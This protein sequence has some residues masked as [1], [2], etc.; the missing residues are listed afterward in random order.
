VERVP[1][2]AERMMLEL[3]QELS[4]EILKPYKAQKEETIIL[5]VGL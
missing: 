1:L 2:V 5:I 4:Q 3:S